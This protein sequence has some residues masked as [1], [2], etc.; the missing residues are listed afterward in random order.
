MIAGKRLVAVFAGAALVMMGV[1][2]ALAARG[3]RRTPEAIPAW[4]AALSSPDS[5]NDPSLER[6]L[7]RLRKTVSRLTPKGTYVVIDTHANQLYLRTA[8]SLIFHAG[9]STGAGHEVVDTLTNR[10]WVFRT[11]RGT[12]KINS[13]LADPWWRKPDWAFIEE[14]E[15]IPKKEADRY[16]EEML[17]DFAMGFGDGYFIHGT[18]YERLLGISVTHGCVRLGADDL[19]YVYE[20]VRIG[21]PVYIF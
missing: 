20:R 1:V 12:F 8:D 4:A 21:T 10:R 15:S 18:L 13:K 16:D 9:C 5:L 6:E 17:G 3:C 14:K 7:R 11:P 19:K 2:V